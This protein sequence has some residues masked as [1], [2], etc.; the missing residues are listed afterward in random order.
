[1]LDCELHIRRVTAAAEQLFNI[2]PVDLGRPIADIRM[3][4]NVDDLQVLMRRVMETL[5]AEELQLQD[6]E[7]RWHLLRVRPYR[8]ADNRIEGAVLTL[9]DIDQIRQE[10]I[11]ADAARD[12]A[13]SVV[14]SVQTPLLVLRSDLR[15]RVA[16]RAFCESYGLQRAEI[17]NQFFHEISEGRW[18]LPG[19]QTALERLPTSR[20]PIE[21]FEIEQEFPGSGKRNLLINARNIRPDGENQIL[22]AVDDVTDEKRTRLILIEGQER[23]QRSLVSGETALHESEAALLRSRNELRALAAKLMQTQAEE[24]RRV[25]RELHDDLS[26]K[27]A[28]L[29]FDVETLEQHPPPDLKSM[30]RRLQTIRDGVGTLS[31]DVR[32]IAYELHPSALDHLGLAIA[33]RAHV[34]EFTEREGIPVRF[35]PRKVPATN[36]SRGRKRSLP[37]RSGSSA[38]CGQARGEDV[39]DHRADWK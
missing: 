22:V 36:S 15:V 29:Q 7:G 31:I 28:K 25:S 17:E 35:T 2:R 4:L 37:N 20:E 5:N 14:Q 8:T 6:L 34:R 19:L 10:Q 33:L 3:W 12:F 39:C 21:G 9:I 1:M 27:I 13:E 26:Q 11:R 16:N 23:L 32:R 30:K 18:N 38:Q 24:R